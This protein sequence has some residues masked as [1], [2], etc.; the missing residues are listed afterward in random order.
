MLSGAVP[1][2]QKS[3]VV[4]QPDST[5]LSLILIGDEHF[6]YY[7]T[8]DGMPVCRMESGAVFYAVFRDS[9]LLVSDILAHDVDDRDEYEQ[10][11]LATYAVQTNVEMQ[12]F[13]KQCI[14]KANEL[15]RKQMKTNR[16]NS[17]EKSNGYIGKKKGLVILVNFQDVA[18]LP[19]HTQTEFNNMFNQVGYSQN[20]H[21]G[22]VHDYFFDQSYG[23]FDLTFDVV[24][25]I[26]VSKNS[27]YY[28]KNKNMQGQDYNVWSMVVEACQQVDNMV[29]FKDYDWDGDG[30][31][32]QVFLIYAGY[33]EQGGGG[34]NLIWS[35]QSNL[36]S[37]AI[38]LDDV[39]INTY[40][41]SCE[42]AGYK[43]SSAL[44][45]IGT[46]CHEFSHCLGLPD[47]YDTNYSDDGS[48]AFGMGAWD[49]MASG[50]H[51]G[52][53]GRGEI[54]YGYSAYERW[55]AGWLDL[56]EIKNTGLI[57]SLPNLGDFPVAYVTYNDG[58]RNEC[59]ILENHQ[60]KRWFC[61]LGDKNSLHGMM[62]SH[63]DYDS[64]AWNRNVVNI[65]AEHQHM[66]IIPADN[67]YGTSSLS[68]IYDSDLF[69][70]VK[71]VTRL[72]NTSHTLVG[73]KLYNK[74]V[75]GTYNMNKGLYNIQETPEGN[76]SFFVLFGP[77]FFP[78]KLFDPTNITND[79]FTINWL[80][81]VNASHYMIELTDE[82]LPIRYRTKII[83]PIYDTTYAFSALKTSNY[84][85][86][87]QAVYNDIFAEWS[88]IYTISLPEQEAKVT[89]LD[90]TN[91]I[92]NYLSPE[93]NILL[94]DIVKLIQKYIEQESDQ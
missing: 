15:R 16:L 5:L 67:A 33:G 66:S 54:P 7:S 47:F 4:R 70:G 19:P 59:Y 2:G 52:P 32:D 31:V 17:I 61:F 45:G 79:S 68:D 93:T 10:K 6:H 75:D 74:N 83:G 55:F 18:F 9:S 26:T 25:P 85:Y 27:T 90:I 24:G 77:D 64:Y 88:S 60:A 71:G 23:M 35:H 56:I 1:S 48:W 51:S 57:E 72:T 8:L 20:S 86:R 36:Y 40:A 91:L 41:C 28:G 94:D 53:N 29:N 78:P 12:T 21:I 46:A 87:V 49:L 14:Q 89:L 50:S 62:V 82:S 44:N 43:P 69:P 22:S 65:N 92:Q 39:M 73:G 80:G 58:N 63:V 84:S 3:F 34:E 37:H 76:I 38:M 42:L 11:Y 13:R 30:K 81:P